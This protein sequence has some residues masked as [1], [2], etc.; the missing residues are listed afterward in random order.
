MASASV[1]YDVSII[2]AFSNLHIFGSIWKLFENATVAEKNPHRGL[3]NS[4]KTHPCSIV[5]LSQDVS[6]D[7]NSRSCKLLIMRVYKKR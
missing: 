4:S 6:H 7:M 5:V 3:D 1:R 2:I